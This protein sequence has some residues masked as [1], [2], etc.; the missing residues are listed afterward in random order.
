MV[1]LIKILTGVVAAL[2]VLLLAA[3]ID[4]SFAQDA[5]AAAAPAAAGRARYR[6]SIPATRPGC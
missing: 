2:A 4:P 5:A 1:T 6:R 3:Y